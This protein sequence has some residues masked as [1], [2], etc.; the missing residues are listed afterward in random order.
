MSY[1]SREASSKEM[2]GH[3]SIGG[4]TATVVGWTIVYCDSN[5]FRC[6]SGVLSRLPSPQRETDSFC[7]H[8]GGS[9][10]GGGDSLGCEGCGDVERD[11]GNE[12]GGDGGNDLGG[13]DLGGNGGGGE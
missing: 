7:T 2:T 4:W 3:T 13:N 12:L 9:S 5:S 11:A 10:G 8:G 6:H 1:G